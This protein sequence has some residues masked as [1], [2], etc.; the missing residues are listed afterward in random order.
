MLSLSNNF[1]DKNESNPMFTDEAYEN[2]TEK[3]YEAIV[4]NFQ[5][6]AEKKLEEQTA[7]LDDIDKLIFDHPFKDVQPRL[8]S[9]V[10]IWAIT[11]KG[12][13]AQLSDIVKNE[14]SVHVREVEKKT[15]S[16]IFI[17]SKMEIPKGQQTLNEIAQAFKNRWITHTYENRELAATTDNLQKKV[18]DDM[19]EWGKRAHVMKKGENVY[20]VVLRGL[21]AKIKTYD[22]H[23]KEEL[24][25]RLWEECSESVD[26]CADGHV[27]RLVN[28]LAGFDDDFQSQMSP[29][30]Y[31]QNNIA[32]IAANDGVSAEFKVA[33]AKKLMDEV[34]MPEAEREAWLSAL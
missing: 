12:P 10:D 15:N 19:K 9:L 7:L 30:E 20:R 24:I 8:W 2:Y 23:T 21:W 22:R 14:Q 28:V 27:G 16:G 4:A 18:L 11:Y 31:F 33:Q 1:L 5:R 25:K 26:L 17:L 6:W 29:M 34:E 13:V 32:L 3:K